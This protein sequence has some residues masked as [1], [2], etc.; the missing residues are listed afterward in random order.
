MDGEGGS[1]KRAR[2]SSDTAP[3]H[4]S[5]SAPMPADSYLPTDAPNDNMATNTTA[6]SEPCHHET[7]LTTLSN[8]VVTMRHLITCKICDRLL[9]EPYGLA[10]GHTYC[11]SCLSNWLVQNHKMTCPDCR[12]N[13]SQQPVPSYLIREMTMIFLNRH[14]LLPDGETKEE[15]EKW[16]K[17]EA[18]IVANDKADM[19]PRTGGLFKG[20]FKQGTNRHL[21]PIHDASDHV[22]RCPACLH[23][24]EDG[25]CEHCGVPVGDDYMS[26]FG[27]SDGEGISS[28]SELDDELEDEDRGDEHGVIWGGYPEDEIDFNEDQRRPDDME[29]VAD[30]LFGGGRPWVNR[31]RHDLS[32]GVSSEE[33]DDDED[34]EDDTNLDG[35]IVGDDEETGRSYF[36][37]TE[38]SDDDGSE[39]DAVVAPRSDWRAAN[40]RRG[41]PI[42]VDDDDE[43]EDEDEDDDDTAREGAREDSVSGG[44]EPAARGVF[45][46]KRNVINRP[47]VRPTAPASDEDESSEDDDEDDDEESE[48]EGDGEDGIS[49]FQAYENHYD[50]TSRADRYGTPNAYPS[51]EPESE[52]VGQ[53][54]DFNYGYDN[55]AQF[56]DASEDEEGSSGEEG[57]DTFNEPTTSSYWQGEEHDYDSSSTA[58]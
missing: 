51:S 52:G 1:R 44:E 53:D 11:Y 3:Q 4:L 28:D 26:D 18:D 54:Y 56:S 20:R 16:A 55:E 17:E 58:G 35:F 7:A 43:D 40:H 34:E 14:E 50:D 42:V 57:R 23:E 47:R 48:G 49:G 9:Y 8:D 19:H 13:V 41:A 25:F 22:M 32:D 2:H 33:D 21:M 24:V 38:R 6:K 15:H 12:S 31:R 29:R 36:G 46:R 39:S 45:G 30:E 27:Y 5:T 10:C 37:R